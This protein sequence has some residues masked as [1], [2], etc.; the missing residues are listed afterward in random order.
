M[1]VFNPAIIY[2]FVF[3]LNN[4]NIYIL[5][6]KKNFFWVKLFIFI[7]FINEIEIKN[8]IVFSDFDFFKC[9]RN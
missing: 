5:S 7:Y 8:R 3:V 6:K 2:I 4:K 1:A 9:V